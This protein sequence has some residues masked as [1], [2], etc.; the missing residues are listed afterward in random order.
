MPC[1]QSYT[2]LTSTE[3]IRNTTLFK[4][5]GLRDSNIGLQT[6]VCSVISL[7]TKN[8]NMMVIIMHLNGI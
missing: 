4:L 2:R 7:H 5:M 6:K 3:L 8:I 1:R